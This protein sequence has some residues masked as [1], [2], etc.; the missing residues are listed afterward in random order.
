MSDFLVSMG[1]NLVLS[2]IKDAVKNPKK[3]EGLK[4]AF[5]KVRDAINLLYPNEV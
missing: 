4:R 2:A 5:L 3:A 1:I